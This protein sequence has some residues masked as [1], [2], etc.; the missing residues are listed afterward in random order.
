MEEALFP[1]H[2]SRLPTEGSRR[3]SRNLCKAELG[4]EGKG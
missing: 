4:K 2:A 1:T 3:A